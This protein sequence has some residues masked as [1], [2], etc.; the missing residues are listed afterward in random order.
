MQIVAIQRLRLANNAAERSC[1]IVHMRVYVCER[2]STEIEICKCFEFRDTFYFW[3]NYGEAVCWQGGQK[4]DQQFLVC[5]QCC[6]KYTHLVVALVLPT[7]WQSWEY[8]LLC[9]WF[10]LNIPIVIKSYRNRLFNHADASATAHTQTY[11]YI[12]ICMCVC[13]LSNQF[14]RRHY[15]NAEMAANCLHLLHFPAFSTLLAL[16]PLFLC[17]SLLFLQHH[18]L[19]VFVCV[20][21]FYSQRGTFY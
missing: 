9:R 2:Y 11:L 16:L 14:G 4:G 6:S 1:I 12:Y 7:D 3:E 19:C 21:D 13:V 17:S 5:M 18:W 10:L 15:G 20:L 8:L